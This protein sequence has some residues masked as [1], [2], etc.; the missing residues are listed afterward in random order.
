MMAMRTMMPMPTL[1]TAPDNTRRHAGHHTTHPSIHHMYTIHIQVVY[2]KTVK[3]ICSSNSV[4]RKFIMNL[5]VR[6]VI[7]VVVIAVQCVSWFALPRTDP[8]V[9]RKFLCTFMC[10]RNDY[11]FTRAIK[12]SSCIPRQN[13]TIIIMK[14]V[15]ATM[16]A[17]G[18][19]I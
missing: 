10:T 19:L 5:F 17:K 15:N 6:E 4:L 7:V 8:Q 14:L 2:V 11:S 16:G 18:H 3:A 9:D 12:F 13:K 1:R